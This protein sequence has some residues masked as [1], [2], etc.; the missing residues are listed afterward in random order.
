MYLQGDIRPVVKRV[1]PYK[2]LLIN[3][4]PKSFGF[5]VLANTKVE[6]CIYKEYN[7]SKITEDILV[8]EENGTS[9]R[10][11]RDLDLD[12]SLDVSDEYLTTDFEVNNNN[13][14][15]KQ[16]NNLNNELKNFHEYLITKKD[17]KD[18]P[19][20]FKRQT[21]YKENLHK[22]V[23]K[24]VKSKYFR[25]ERDIFDLKSNLLDKLI[26]F[27]NEK[28]SKISKSRFNRKNI[29]RSNKIQ[30][31]E[32]DELNEERGNRKRRSIHDEIV[33][34]NTESF[35]KDKKY[36]YKSIENEIDSDDNY[37]P[38]DN[39][40][41]GSL[42]FPLKINNDNDDLELNEITLKTKLSEDG[43][44]INISEKANSG[45]LRFT[46]EDIVNMLVDFNKKI[47]KF[48]SVLTVLD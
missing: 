11:K 16:I 28:L 21:D 4:P 24:G 2:S 17:N 45:L 18:F 6:A 32:Y 43:A 36:L 8:D 48:W 19:I 33:K 40:L 25:N 41:K 27:K 30:S 1:R 46:F 20:R 38:V 39:K 7:E 10:N 29:K 37:L 34:G 22:S 23:R 5:W 47:N 9:Q 3:L 13:N 42:H 12:K 26:A 15:R 35:R 31:N 14:L 44:V